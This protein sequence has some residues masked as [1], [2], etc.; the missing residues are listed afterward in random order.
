[1]K[2]KMRED[3]CFL[4]LLVIAQLLR[5]IDDKTRKHYQ[6]REKDAY[7]A[8]SE[9]D[10]IAKLVD[11]DMARRS[12]NEMERKVKNRAVWNQQFGS[13]VPVLMT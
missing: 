3:V 4:F 2:K 13:E 1:M 7:Y 6:D 5:M 12:R 9:A 11:E 10:R 8:H